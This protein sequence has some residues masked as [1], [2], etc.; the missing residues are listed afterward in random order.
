LV[1]ASATNGM[2]ASDPAGWLWSG[3]GLQ[4]GQPRSRPG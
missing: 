1:T 2:L 4:W 3:S